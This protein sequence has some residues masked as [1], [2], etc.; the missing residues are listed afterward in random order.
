MS[1]SPAHLALYDGAA[2]MEVGHILAELHTGRFTGAR[3]DVA[4][5]AESR[6]PI[7]TMGELRIVPDAALADLTPTQSELT[8][9]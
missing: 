5:I 1:T 2:D 6:V 7:T 9:S 8:R 3:F 4:T